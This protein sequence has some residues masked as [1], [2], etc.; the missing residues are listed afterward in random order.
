MEG[1]NLN[2]P[3]DLKDLEQL[4]I[5]QIYWS[6]VGYNIKDV[7]GE[8]YYFNDEEEFLPYTETYYDPASNKLIED[9]YDIFDINVNGSEHI[10]LQETEELNLKDIE[11]SY[12]S[13]GDG[14][15]AELTYLE[16]IST[17][18]F[19]E[20]NPEIVKLKARYLLSLSRYWQYVKNPE[21]DENNEYTL[22]RVKS[23]YKNLVDALE[24][25][26]I[27]DLTRG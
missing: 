23:D 26:I 13:I 8:I 14:I 25:V 1:D 19:E 10:N 12:L 7:D 22:E 21:I 24:K 2:H 6:S 27:E 17:Y 11:F 20:T 18:S 9:S 4:S 16:Q 15:L 5:Y 3:I